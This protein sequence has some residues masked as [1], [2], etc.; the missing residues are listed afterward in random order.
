M[1]LRGGISAQQGEAAVSLLGD[2]YQQPPG[3]VPCHTQVS[4]YPHPHLHATVE[5]ESKFLSLFWQEKG[6]KKKQ[7]PQA[8]P[9]RNLSVTVTRKGWFLEQEVPSTPS[10]FCPPQSSAQLQ[11][12][13]E[14]AGG[15]NAA[16]AQV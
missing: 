7:K 11:C 3:Q 4:S 8:E 2:G 13:P 5:A 10:L 15:Q 6:K 9:P 14:W 12:D 16:T 1:L